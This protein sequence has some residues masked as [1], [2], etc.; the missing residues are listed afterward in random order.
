MT[1]LRVLFV[2]E[3]ELG[4]A[5]MGHGSL[6]ASLEVG[7]REAEDVEA[8]FLGIPPMGRAAL[9]LATAAPPVLGRLDL[10]LQ[11]S[12]W[13]AVQGIRAR[14]AIR[15]ALRESPADVL[16]VHSHSLALL[17]GGVMRR[18]PTVL[19]MD[20]SVWE[21]HRMAIWAP[22][23][24]YS[25]LAVSPSIVAERRALRRAA[26]T[27]AWSDWALRG[28]RREEP[29]ARL[30]QLHPG[31]DLGVFSPGEREARRRPRVLFVGGRFVE[32]GGEDLLAALGPGLGR[33][34]D[35]DIVTPADVADTPGVTRHRLRPGDPALVEL[36]RQADVFCLPTR[37]DSNP[38]VILEAMACGTPVV[39]TAVG[40]I[41]ELLGNGEAGVIVPPGDLRALRDGLGGLLR[42]APRRRQMGAAARRRT[43]EHYDARVQTRRLLESLRRVAAR[44]D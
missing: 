35:L 24:R 17:L 26:L 29:R 33:D 16:H 5:V 30:E 11:T 32:K 19:S 34:V 12:R 36:Y 43:E 14:R 38:W 41:P 28:A 2:N 23:R 37:G 3:G 1:P 15:R 42:D 25:R 6:D 20:V 7:L 21:W 4:P 27:V 13:H 18:V 44:R 31:L 22:L 10:D 40:A 9:K 8:R 39:S